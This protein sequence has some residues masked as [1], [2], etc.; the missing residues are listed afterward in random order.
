MFDFE[1]KDRDPD[2]DA[3]DIESG[4]LLPT[5]KYIVELAN[6]IAKEVNGKKV[7]E[8]S[9]EVVEGKF[10]GRKVK[11]DLF[12]EGSDAEKTTKMQNQCIHFGLKLGLL[13]VVEKKGKKTYKYLKDSF[14]DCAGTQVVVNV[15]H[16]S[17][18]D[19]KDQKFAKVGF[20]GIYSLEDKEAKELLKQFN[21][22]G[23]QVDR[24]EEDEEAVNV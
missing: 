24:E 5:G 10:K 12:H 21:R 20:F 2:K 16:N 22:S 17:H 18:P 9:F 8:L 1:I 19:N 23:E 7:D 3:K 13:G 15:T 4:G 6:H 11:A 14:E